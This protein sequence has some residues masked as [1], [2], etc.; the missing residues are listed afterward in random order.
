MFNFDVIT[1]GMP[2]SLHYDSTRTQQEDANRINKLVKNGFNLTLTWRQ[3]NSFDTA[4][5]L[6]PLVNN[7]LSPD[8]AF[9]TGKILDT[10]SYTKK[11]IENVDL[12][13]SM[14]NDKESVFGSHDN[15]K[16]N[17]KAIF[18][19]EGLLDISWK[20]VDWD[21]RI[22]YFNESSLLDNIPPMQQ[23][24]HSNNFDYNRRFGSSVSM[25]STGRVIITDRLHGS[26][27]AFLMNKPH[28]YI[29]Q[30]YKKIEKTRKISFQGI[31]S[32]SN[33]KLL[34]YNLGNHVHFHLLLL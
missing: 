16:A 28:V 11:G 32:C 22:E 17:L 13:F 19:S 3:Q 5:A 9:L 33:K 25:F 14:R 26:I 8:I 10:T 18:T 4:K 1:V 30:M 15:I 12:L 20:V 23:V 29:D 24:P 6:Y 27:F 31:P 2:Q 34:K 21:S 7:I